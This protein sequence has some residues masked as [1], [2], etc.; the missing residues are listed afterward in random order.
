MSAA[1]ERASSSVRL[2]TVKEEPVTGEAM[3]NGRSSGD[4]LKSVDKLS[5]LSGALSVFTSRWKDL[6]SHLDSIQ[7]FIQQLEG[8]SASSP[9]FDIDPASCSHEGDPRTELEKICDTVNG[10]A[11]RKYIAIRLSDPGNL[12]EELQVAFKRSP[13]LGKLVISCMGRFYIQGSRAFEKQSA[14]VS[15]RE[16]CILVLECFLLAGGCAKVVDS[17]IKSEAQDSAVA[18]KMRLVKE[19]GIENSKDVDAQGLLLFVASFGVPPGFGKDDLWQLMQSSKMN[20]NSDALRASPFLQQKLDDMLQGIMKNGRYVAAVDLSCAFGLEEKFPP[21]AL[22]LS[23][24]NDI[25]KKGNQMRREGQN[26]RGALKA[27]DEKQLRDLK[28]VVKC[29]ERY[30]LDPAYFSDWK[31]QEKIANLEKDISLFTNML[32]ETKRKAV[33]QRARPEKHL[34]SSN[35]NLLPQRGSP[36]GLMSLHQDPMRV[37]DERYMGVIEEYSGASRS[38]TAAHPTDYMAAGAAGTQSLLSNRGTNVSGE[39]ALGTSDLI[40]LAAENR[41]SALTRESGLLSIPTASADMAHDWNQRNALL[42]IREGLYEW[43]HRIANAGVDSRDGSYEWL[44]RNGAKDESARQDSSVYLYRP[45]GWQTSRGASSNRENS[46]LYHLPDS[47]FEIETSYPN[48]TDL[49]S[50]VYKHRAPYY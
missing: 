20:K 14:I 6:Q 11:L 26:S 43:H 2:V 38:P 42:G 45:K 39:V 47:R 48:H 49:S 13:D 34:R 21:R 32:K 35:L 12:R 37:L 1:A 28:S 24:L 44:Q 8:S 25:N 17:P 33:E 31:I 29:I 46:N 40:S 4:L 27:A 5:G 23:F 30:Q 41:S 7:K 10:K 19:G 15:V 50:P 16:A 36:G 22:L 18:W 3:E 9:E